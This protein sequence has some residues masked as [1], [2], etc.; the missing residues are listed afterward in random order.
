MSDPRQ[1]HDGWNAKRQLAFL[2]TYRR[3]RSATAAAKAAGMSRE[4]AYR[5]CR[6]EPD[7]LFAVTWAHLA[8][9]AVRRS[10]AE[11]DQGHIAVIRRGCGPEGHAFR[12]NRARGSSS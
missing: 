4:S 2:E 7:G 8:G 6:R 10:Q 9:P 5:L 12:L 1:R 11:I 3:T